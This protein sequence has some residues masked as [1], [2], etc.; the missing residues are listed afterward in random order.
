MSV[1]GR[2]MQMNAGAAESQGDVLVFAHADMRF[3]Q[4]AVRRIRESVESGVVGGGFFK[5]YDPSSVL[6]KGYGW[7][8]NHLYLTRMRNLVG[9]NGIFVTRTVFEALGGFPDQPLLEDVAFSSLLKHAG[10]L[11]VVRDAIR[12]SSRRYGKRGV[13]SQIVL[14]ARILAGYSLRKESPKTLKEK[15]GNGKNRKVKPT[16]ENQSIPI[17]AQQRLIPNG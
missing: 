9:T 1:A 12:V 11:S 8:L 10:R 7:C 13:L 15:Y 16:H 17:I 4:S 5:Q 6:L 3:P 14:N 2:A